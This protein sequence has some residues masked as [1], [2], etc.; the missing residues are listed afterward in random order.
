MAAGSFRDPTNM[1]DIVATLI[2][3]SHSPEA[4]HAYREFLPEKQQVQPLKLVGIEVLQHFPRLPGACAMMSA[5]QQLSA[6]DSSAFFSTNQWR[7]LLDSQQ[8]ND[9]L[10]SSR[11]S[12]FLSLECD[13]V[14]QH[15]RG[16]DVIK[17]L[18][19]VT[20]RAEPSFP[21]TRPFARRNG[22]AVG[23]SV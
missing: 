18:F 3:R 12:V 2:A 11:V 5:Q 20:S 8:L 17:T 23:Q 22:R 13:S 19:V 9:A 6:T 21:C 7:T 14:Q 15:F 10:D 1:I 4:A 16:N